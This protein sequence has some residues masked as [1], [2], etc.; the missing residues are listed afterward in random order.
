MSPLEH[1]LA[2][3]EGVRPQGSGFI[4]LCPAHDDHRPSLGVSLGD[5]GR[6][7]V[8]CRAGCAAAEV[9]ASIGLTFEDLFPEGQRVRGG[10]DQG[11]T[12]ES[13]AAAK[14]LPVDFLRGLGCANMP[15][16]KVRIPYPDP[17]GTVVAV[18]FRTALEGARF[19]WRKG[20]HVLPY[21]LE[22]LS[23][24]REAGWVLLVEGETD[25]W[26]AWMLGLPALGI[27]GKSTW[28]SEWAKYLAGIEVV[29]V[30]QEPSAE[31]LVDRIARDLPDVLVIP[32]PASAKDISE[33][34]VRGVDV[35]ALLDDLKGVARPASDVVHERAEIRLGEIHRAAAP[36]L[37]HP[38][39]L[40]LVRAA[41]RDQGYGGDLRAPLLVYVAETTRVLAIRPG[42][43]A[44]HL[45]LMGPPSS[46]K[47][48]TEAAASRLLPAESIHRIDA[49]SSRVLI[50]D[51]EPLQHRVVI[52]G[53][54]DSLPAGEDNPA[55]SAIRGLLQDGHLHY[56]VTV[57]DPTTGDFV[58]RAI[59]KAGPTVLLTTSTRSLG[60]QLMSRLFT[61]EVPDEPEQIRAAL[62]AQATLELDGAPA[63]ADEL[64]AFQ[65][66][67]QALAPIDVIVPF[68]RQLSTHLGHQPVGPR[69]QRDYSRLL[70]LVKAVAVV[71]IAHRRRDGRGRLIATIDDYSTVYELVRETYEASSGASSRVRDVV[72]AVAAIARTKGTGSSITTTAVADFLGISV[73]SAWRRIK[74]AI[75]GG[76]LVNRETRK[77]QPARLRV[78]EAMPATSGLPTPDELRGLKLTGS[79]E[80]VQ[81]PG[82]AAPKVPSPH[83]DPPT[84]A[85]DRDPSLDTDVAGED[86]L[87]VF[88]VS[89]DTAG[90]P[91]P[92]Q[93]QPAIDLIG[94]VRQ[95]LEAG[96]LERAS[97][98]IWLNSGSRVN[99][100]T[101]AA[102]SWLSELDRPG[103][104]GVAAQ[105]H[106]E[107]LGRA[108]LRNEADA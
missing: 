81:S 9:L 90:G 66:Y 50:Y 72:E 69:V 102:T 53:E 12:L 44:A 55:A 30:W 10:S 105:A 85:D 106:L 107:E 31:D 11:L 84:T 76:W 17:D 47:N 6:V 32:A 49:G 92:R 18:R 13:L 48:A 14:H 100:P 83:V 95:R 80:N 8:L 1:V 94:L 42:A 89:P 15:G 58:V 77:G 46:G 24:A 61:I 43:M 75:A 93:D 54:A 104:I 96:D 67:L 34:H 56:R 3:L 64:I 2:L 52:F 38:D 25:C 35:V 63:P 101:R 21:G 51:D 41:I 65:A 91:T 22:R 71:R 20:D 5:D 4:A 37:A 70:A 23:Q 68:A 36:V 59:D 74:E 39:P 62:E 28:R 103:V 108:L 7:L 99:D 88:T 29:C 33:A 45:I 57:R 86:A 98:P 87:P 79:L 97:G 16:P 40:V 60:D 26:T 27:P 19:H 78:G 73:P 82:P